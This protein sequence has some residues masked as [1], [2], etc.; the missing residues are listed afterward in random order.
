MTGTSIDGIDAAMI[1]IT[2][3]GAGMSARL[4]RQVHEPIG[5]LA[6][7]LRAFARGGRLTAVEVA[8]LARR[9]G[10]RHAGVFE[11]HFATEPL[12]IIVVHGQTVCHAPPDS[13]QLINPWPLAAIA[14]CPVMYDLRGEDLAIG[15][16]GAPITPI[17]DAILYR[18]Q[19]DP[20]TALAIVNLGGFINATLLPS[21]KTRADLFDGLA[22]FD[23]CPCNHLLDAA[24]LAVINRPFDQGGKIAVSGTPDALTASAFG[25]K[26]A[27]L[28]HDERSGG[29]GDE[30]RDEA[31]ALVRAAGT[32]ADGLATICQAI[33]IALHDCISSA[34]RRFGSAQPSS[35]ILAG[36]GVLNECL[37]DAIRTAFPPSTDVRT[38]DEFSLPAQARES[39]GMATLGA[40][41]CDGV[42]ITESSIT[43]RRLGTLSGPSITRS[44]F[45]S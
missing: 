26:I 1:E 42:S 18:D 20:D 5:E 29:D 13:L 40:L 28:F 10:E 33:G 3:H 6:E 38:S 16:Q 45:S 7:P 44:R 22:G 34:S 36:G 14:P 23:C 12:D 8:S 4:L 21:M 19:R 25:R 41:A 39:A 9:F 27:A 37:V 17:A 35:L 24:S 15:G 31:V 32:P 2:G 11:A 43:G 30:H